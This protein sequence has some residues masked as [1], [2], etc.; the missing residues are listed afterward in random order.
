MADYSVQRAN[1]LWELMQLSPAKD[2]FHSHDLLDS[3]FRTLP[4]PPQ[5]PPMFILR[6]NSVSQAL[7]FRPEV[8]PRCLRITDLGEPML[9]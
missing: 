1:P 9:P 8:R 5:N 4:H 7:A 6:I 2:V 3:Y